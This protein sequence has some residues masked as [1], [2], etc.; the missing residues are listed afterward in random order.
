MDSKKKQ[1]YVIT[2]YYNF[3]DAEFAFKDEEVFYTISGRKA[4]RKMK[5]L[6]ADETAGMYFL[7]EFDLI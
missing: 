7:E 1:I 2:A 3:K 4:D 5:E 6:E